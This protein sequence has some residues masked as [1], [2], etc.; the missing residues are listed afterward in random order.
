[1]NASMNSMMWKTTHRFGALMLALLLF[2]ATWE[3]AHD[4]EMRMFFRVPGATILGILGLL[5]FLKCVRPGA[6]EDST[7]DAGGRRL[8]KARS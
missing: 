5:A 8:G 3:V 7:R 6:Q 1:M 2:F 4:E